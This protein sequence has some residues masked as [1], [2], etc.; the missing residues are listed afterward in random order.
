M[1]PPLGFAKQIFGAPLDHA[2]SVPQK[3]LQHLLERQGP[4]PPLDQRQE[5]DARRLLEGGE[6]IELVQDQVGV[7]VALDVDDEPHRLSAASA[8]FVANRADSLDPL[9]LDQLAD[10]LRQPVAGLLERDLAD[11]DLR[12]V[13]LLADVGPGPQRDLAPAGHVAV[14]NPLPA[15]DDA[16]GR[17]VGAR[18]D[19]HELIDG[20]VRVVDDLDDGSADL[21]QVVRRDVRRH[22]DRDAVGTV[23]EE[24]GEL[25]R[26]YQGLTVSA[27][28]G[29][30]VIDGVAFKVGEHLGG[31]RR[32]A[33]FGVSHGRRRQP[34][35][36]P[37]IPLRMHEAVA[38]GPILRHSHQRGIDDLLAVR[39]V[40]LHRLADDTCA[41]A[42]GGGRPEAE[43][44]HR[45]ED[46]PLRRLEAVASIGQRPADNDA[47][48]VG[49]IAV[50]ELVFDVERLVAIAVTT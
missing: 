26:Q 18:K 27:V 40:A 21:A 25:A 35:D 16:A 4:R 10:R 3:L 43:V 14:E 50:L 28:V 9:V 41:L 44:V 48:R 13:P 34:G 5:D 46:A 45:D 7:G 38:H 15:A 11:N 33:G 23:D 19:L 36:R 12:S 47:H 24:V 20:H 42:G 30:D 6:L 1:R 31:D 8:A 22:A 32:Q 17:E 37:E 29:V 49:E 39:V 2:H